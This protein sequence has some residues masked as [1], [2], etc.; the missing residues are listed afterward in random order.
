MNQTN[1]LSARPRERIGTRYARRVREGGGL[2]AVLYGHK[3]EPLSIT[4]D[5]REA[6]RFIHGGQ[7]VFTLALE[8]E[9]QATALLKDLQ[10]DHMG[11]SVIHAD[12]ERVDLNEEV[13]VHL[14]VRLIGD[15][16]GLKTAGA[17]LLHPVS[18]VTVRCKV[19]DI[20]EFLDV[21]VSALDAGQSLHARQATLPP[22]FALVS[23]AEAVLAGIQVQK[24]IE[25]A[26]VA[27]AAP[28]E[29]A[30]GAEPEVIR[31]RKTGEEGAP[32]PAKEGK[33]A[34]EGKKEG[35]KKE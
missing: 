14:S 22:G 25:V 17:I 8:G 2:P 28:V 33:E 9:G 30:A 18:E 5:A 20:M 7:K 13:E 15:A 16:V 31:E 6:L 4:L 27:E 11:T 10:F 34:K 29:G 1:T 12:F 24:E 26:V 3:K 35:K 32:E 19:K 23:D 21:D